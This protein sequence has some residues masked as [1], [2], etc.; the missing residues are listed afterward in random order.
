MAVQA[1]ERKCRNTLDGNF[2]REGTA[3]SY[4]SPVLELF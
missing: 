1:V 4:K 3:Y 2:L